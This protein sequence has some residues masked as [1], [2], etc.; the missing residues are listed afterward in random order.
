MSSAETDSETD[1]TDI[2]GIGPSYAE[3]LRD[4]GYGTVEDVA[5]A[6]VDEIDDVIATHD[7]EGL[8]ENAKVLLDDS[9]VEFE[10]EPEEDVGDER[11][12][13]DIDMTPTQRNHFI[14]GMVNEEIRARRTNKAGDVESATS[15]IETLVEGPPYTFTEAQLD[16]AYRALNQIESEYRSLRGI[17]SFVTE[18]RN[19]CDAVQAKRSE[20]RE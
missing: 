14:K 17:G 9:S 18:I 10:D 12:E 1:L 6:D 20:L 3:Q 13:L 19:L 15:A 4:N 2:T 7:G 16:T 11:Y 5:N 8:V